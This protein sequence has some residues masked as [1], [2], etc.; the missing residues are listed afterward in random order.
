MA[1]HDALLDPVNGG[2]DREVGGVQVNMTRAG[3]G[4]VRR[5]IY[6]AGFRWSTH[7]KKLIGTDLCQHAHVGFIVRG[8]IEI[9]YADKR[10]AAF[11]APQAVVIEPGHEGWVS[12]DGPAVMIEVDFEGDTA[13]VFGLTD[14]FGFADD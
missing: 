8:K 3:K 2:E 7:M 12:G 13:R 4:R 10:R 11:V 6:P 5:V 14:E 9:E 1:T